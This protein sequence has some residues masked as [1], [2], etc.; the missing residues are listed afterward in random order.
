MHTV[1]VEILK[2][3]ELLPE[4]K[5][6]EIYDFIHFFRIGLQRSKRKNKSIMD[7]AGIWKDLPGKNFNE[8]SKEIKMRRRNEI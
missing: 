2:E 1:R 6:N 8:F 5:L 7:F 3:I 4:E